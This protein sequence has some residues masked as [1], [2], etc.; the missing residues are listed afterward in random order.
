MRTGGPNN[1]GAFRYLAPLNLSLALFILFQ[2]SVVITHLYKDRSR[3]SS[4]LFLLIAVCDVI[5][6]LSELVRGSVALSCLRDNQIP[7]PGLLVLGY[8]SVGVL[9]YQCS[10]FFN[11]VLTILKT[12]QIINPFYRVNSPVLKA[13]LLVFPLIGFLVTI[14]DIICWNRTMDVSPS[15]YHHWT[16][17]EAVSYV[18]EGMVV[19]LKQSKK[20]ETIAGGIILNL[21]YSLS[22][23]M[24]LVCMVVQMCFIKRAFMGGSESGQYVAEHANLTVFLV[25]TLYFIS[26]SAFTIVFS[27]YFSGYIHKFNNFSYCK[28]LLNTAKFTLPLLNAALFPLIIILR[29]PSLRMQYKELLMKILYLP[30][31]GYYRVR[32]WVSGRRGF[33]TLEEE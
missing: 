33:E 32:N 30:S 10:I 28:M 19:Y 21:D 5:T 16:K 4:L 12:V 2:N 6:A 1:Q 3:Y 8:L 13:A 15:C 25:S 7:V 26:N 20:Q 14:G 9:S 23:L 22:C 11:L 17:L 29:K 18:G 24:V 31:A 27:L